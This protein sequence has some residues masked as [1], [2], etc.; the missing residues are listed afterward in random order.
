MANN[1]GSE[2]LYIVLKGGL[3]RFSLSEPIQGSGQYKCPEP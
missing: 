2:F 3:K 1:A